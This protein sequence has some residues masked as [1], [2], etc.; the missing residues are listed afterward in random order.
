MMRQQ[1]DA[2][3]SI[4]GTLHIISQQ[5]SLMGNEIEEHIEYVLVLDEQIDFVS[6][7]FF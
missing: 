6:P 7:T 2:M 1:D 5:A 4:S 3:D